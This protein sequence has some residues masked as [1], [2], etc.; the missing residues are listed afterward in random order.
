MKINSRWIIALLSLTLFTTGCGSSDTSESDAKDITTSET[1]GENSDTT[2]EAPEETATTIEEQ[3]IVNQN[4]IVITATDY[5]EDGFMGDSINLLIE[6]NSDQNLTVGCDALIVN[7]YMISNLFVSDV[8]AGKK[9][10]E[11]LDLSSSELEAA[12]IE[13]VGQVE[14]Y[15]RAYDTATY[16][17]VFTADV[18]TIQTSNFANMDTTPNDEGTELYNA[19]GVR[20]VGKMVDE[21]SF[22][23]TAVLLYIENNSGQNIG[24]QCDNMSINGFMM[25]PLF[26]SDVYNGKKAIDD[27]TILSSEL[28]ANGIESVSEVELQFHIFDVDTYDTIA[29]SEPIT[30]SVQ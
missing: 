20:I 4:G 22:W 30:F 3:V 17:D 28:E 21:D 10:N 7:G 2:T 8:A 27:I 13:S 6:N 14:V 25:S 24:V 5:A 26:S 12:G 18:A 29:D 9:V 15:F 23:G 19:G 16:E 1:S 11:T